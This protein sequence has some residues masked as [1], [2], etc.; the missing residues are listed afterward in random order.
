MPNSSGSRIVTPHGIDVKKWLWGG[1]VLDG[2][3]LEPPLLGK[4]TK[5]NLKETE[6]EK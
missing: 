2:A 5:L 4:I 1:G 3:S 6:S